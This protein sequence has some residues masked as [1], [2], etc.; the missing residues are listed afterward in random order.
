VCVGDVSQATAVFTT[1][2]AIT[3]VNEM[4]ETVGA[5][6]E[7][8]QRFLAVRRTGGKSYT[9]SASAAS[10]AMKRAE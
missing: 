6:A 1:R 3:D 9:R 10:Q 4:A 7:Q 5:I 2:C 8:A